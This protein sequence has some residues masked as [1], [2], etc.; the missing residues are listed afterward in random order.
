M[1]IT[2]HMCLIYNSRI[3]EESVARNSNMYVCVW[4]RSQEFRNPALVASTHLMCKFRTCRHVC[5]NF[6]MQLCMW[7]RKKAPGIQECLANAPKITCTQFGT[8]E[9]SG[10]RTYFCPLIFSYIFE[11][12][13][14]GNGQEILGTH[15]FN[16]CVYRD[17]PGRRIGESTK[18]P[19]P[20]W[21]YNK[22]IK[23]LSIVV[24]VIKKLRY[25]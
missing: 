25:Y 6:K 7:C 16:L 23:V 1:S 17:R 24:K 11:K 21:Y 8:P 14:T 15:K 2:S 3:P 22:N 9:S 12:N 5:F 19:P 4:K 10:I 20:S 18:R 13:S